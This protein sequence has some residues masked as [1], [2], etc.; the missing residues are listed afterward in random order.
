MSDWSLAGI[1]A[2]I[3]AFLTGLFAW[4]T[5]RSKS[6]SDIEV[7]VIAEWQKLNAALASRVSALE[8]LV[9]ELRRDHADEI[10]ELRK[11]HR[12][13]MRALRE[14]NEGLQ[15]QIAQT[16]HSTAHLLSDKITKDKGDGD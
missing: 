15:R 10:D 7:A 8:K 1:G 12:T 2:V 4:L 6:G 14:Q 9:S 3:G 5:Q 13:E 11:Q 16:S